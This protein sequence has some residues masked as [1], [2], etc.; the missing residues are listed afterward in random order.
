MEENLVQNWIETDKNLFKLITE[1]ESEINS[2]NEQAEVA[3]E[4]L[5]KL[6]NIPRMPVDVP[7]E[8]FEDEDEFDKRSLFEEHALI[9]YLAE[10]NEDPRGIVLSAAFHLLNDYRIDLFQVAE[11]EFGQNIPE[12]CKIGIIGEGFN[13]EVV[14]P[15]KEY[16]SWFEL[17]CKIMKQIN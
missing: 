10:E 3:F 12:K 7:E 14:F 4:R 17:G 5:S 6:Y 1:I 8:E 16:K 15:Q 13:G 2:Y 11:K 9:K